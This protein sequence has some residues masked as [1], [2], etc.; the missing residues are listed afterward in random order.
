MAFCTVADQTILEA[1]GLRERALLC[2]EIAKDYH[3]S[4]GAPLWAKARELE[5]HA[6]KLERRGVERRVRR[7]HRAA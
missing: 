7:V 3:P 5:R 1:E 2:R 6:A 4:V